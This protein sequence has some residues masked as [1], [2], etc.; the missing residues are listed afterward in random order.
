M[1][2]LENICAMIRQKNTLQ[3]MNLLSSYIVLGGGK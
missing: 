3:H 2:S 1:I